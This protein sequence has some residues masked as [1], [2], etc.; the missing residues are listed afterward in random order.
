MT[1]K[2]KAS[3]PMPAR[4]NPGDDPARRPVPESCWPTAEGAHA[5]VENEKTPAEGWGF[6]I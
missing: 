6:F 3:H 1:G 5:R 2:T 4:F